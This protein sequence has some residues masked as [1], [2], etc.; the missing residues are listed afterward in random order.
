MEPMTLR[1][2]A[3][4]VGGE[5]PETGSDTRVTGV[6]LDSR[7][8]TEGDLFVALAGARVDGADFG[9]DAAR[10]R[11]VAALAR[12]PVAGLPTVVVPDEPAALARLGVACR[13]AAG[14]RVA[15]ITGS[16]GK[17]T[18]KELLAAMLGSLGP[19]LATAGN[20][21]N[22]LGVPLTLCRLNASHRY[23]VIEMG[24]NH[25]G[26]I[27]ALTRWAAPDVGVVT[28]AAPAHL[29][30]FG[31]LDGVARAK[32]ELFEELGP[33][34]VAVV[35]ADD[36][37]APLWRS[38]AGESRVVTFGAGPDA[39]L[40]FRGSGADLELRWEGRWI[41]VP[42]PL[43]GRHNAANVAAAAACAWV[44]GAEPRNVTA[45]VAAT[46]GVPGRLQ[47]QPGAGG[48]QILDDSYNANPASLEAGLECL[49]A[50]EGERWLLLGEMAELGAEAESWH[51]KAAE[52]ARRAGVS[53][54]WTVGAAA[55]AAEAFGPGGRA[56]DDR[57]A[58]LAALRDSLP[59]TAVV[60]IKG[61]RAAGMDRIT[62]ALTAE[63]TPA[64]GG[65]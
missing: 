2:I 11:A 5:T 29:E 65:D 20:L 16:N 15:G 54:L 31:S 23:A 19:T 9:A 53:H 46:T 35:N 37:Y 10:R 62:V 25:P 40:A 3:G 41:P 49:A 34:G 64:Q 7:A 50:L 21:N 14:A 42:S 39:D 55:P 32:G 48:Q 58:L 28:Q 27:R 45:A 13:R 4:V 56:F 43:P 1:E 52:A 33:E 57:A 63:S 60:L 47:P 8:V 6:A 30:G 61:S 59:E 18:V 26:E 38:Q 17:T 44:F 24:A 36:P 51:R 22:E 12:R